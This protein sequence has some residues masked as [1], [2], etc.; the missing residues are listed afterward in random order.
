[1]PVMIPDGRTIG[2]HWEISV[3]N[4]L[5][6]FVHRVLFAGRWPICGGLWGGLKFLKQIRN[7][8]LYPGGRLLNLAHRFGHLDL[9]NLCDDALA[10]VLRLIHHAGKARIFGHATQHSA[11]AE[12]H[13][14]TQHAD[15]HA[16]RH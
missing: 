2:D 6:S 16:Y 9:S 12:Q 1:M 14:D 15:Q 8:L 10:Q 5:S 13:A 7:G 4:R 3:V 11:A